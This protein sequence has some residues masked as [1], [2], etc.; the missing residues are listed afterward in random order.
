MHQYLWH[1]PPCVCLLLVTQG[2][3]NTENAQ[4]DSN[5]GQGDASSLYICYHNT[6]RVVKV[7][8]GKL[9]CIKGQTDLWG[10][11]GKTVMLT[12]S[13][14]PGQRGLFEHKSVFRL[15]W[16][17]RHHIY[18]ENNLSSIR[19]TNSRYTKRSFLRC[20]RTLD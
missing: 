12:N 15:G 6:K 14:L 7:Y 8:V 16:L 13:T 10:L 5:V 4:R 11:G 20:S 19:S 3:G 2:T 17:S 18:T 9:L 1:T